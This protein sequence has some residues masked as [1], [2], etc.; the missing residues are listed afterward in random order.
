M[1]FPC[2]A[3]ICRSPMIFHGR[4]RKGGNETVLWRVI[5]YVSLRNMQSASPLGSPSLAPPHPPFDEVDLALCVYHI[6]CSVGIKC[7]VMPKV[8]NPR[9]TRFLPSHAEAS[10]G[11]GSLEPCPK[12]TAAPASAWTATRRMSPNSGASCLCCWWGDCSAAK[13]AWVLK[14]VRS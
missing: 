14:G 11:S 7:T 8:P 3:P 4:L 9:E 6:V 13:S 1:R 5:S 2:S 12:S 10:T